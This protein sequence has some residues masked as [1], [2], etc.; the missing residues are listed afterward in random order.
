MVKIKTHVPEA[1]TC[2]WSKYDRN[3]I[4]TG[5][6]DGHIK[7]WDLRNTSSPCFELMVNIHITKYGIVN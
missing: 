2:D 4:A 5:G 6:V 7:G 1:L 3:A